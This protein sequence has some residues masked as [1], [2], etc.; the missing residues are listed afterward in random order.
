MYIVLLLLLQEN[1]QDNC[2]LQNHVNLLEVVPGS[3]NETYHPGD[4]GLNVKQEEF[5]D[6]EGETSPV[7]KTFTVIKAEPGVSYVSIHYFLLL[8][9]ILYFVLSF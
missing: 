3:Y 7:P 9:N 2:G 6:I 5:I 8:T 1:N 4:Q